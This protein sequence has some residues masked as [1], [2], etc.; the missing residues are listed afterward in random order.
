MPMD[1]PREALD[2]IDRFMSGHS[3]ADRVLPSDGA[4]IC[5]GGVLC[6]CADT[7]NAS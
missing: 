6:C 3:F 5:G 2:M 1:K 7:D 4:Y